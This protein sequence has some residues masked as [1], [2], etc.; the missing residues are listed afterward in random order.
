VVS[1]VFTLKRLGNVCGF[2]HANKVALRSLL[3]PILNLLLLLIGLH[4]KKMKMNRD[5]ELCRSEILLKKSKSDINIV[6]KL[7]LVELWKDIIFNH[8]IRMEGS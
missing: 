5:F 1:I 2:P 8:C 3:R 4:N 7:I 6:L